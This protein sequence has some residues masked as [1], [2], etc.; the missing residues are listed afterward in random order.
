MIVYYTITKNLK[1]DLTVQLTR[2]SINSK[3]SAFVDT[4]GSAQYQ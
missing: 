3:Q 2:H 4:I 1:D